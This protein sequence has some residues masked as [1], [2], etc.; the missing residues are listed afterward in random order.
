MAS[1]S[2]CPRGGYRPIY[3]DADLIASQTPPRVPDRPARVQVEE[4]RKLQ[5]AEHIGEYNIWY[6]KYTGENSFERAARA[7]TRVCLETDAGLT[8]VDHTDPGA[9]ICLHFARGCCIAGKDC[10]YRHCAPTDADE[11]RLDGE[12][13]ALNDCFGRDRHVSFR[14]DMGG[15]GT[16]NRDC[17]TL[18]IGRVCAI[19][20]EEEMKQTLIAHF[21]EFGVLESVRVLKNKGAGFIT[22]TLR[23]SA[24]FAK[25]AMAEQA[26]DHDEQVSF[27]PPIFPICHTSF[28]LYIDY[29]SQSDQRAMGARRSESSRKGDAAA[30]RRADDARCNGGAR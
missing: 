30:K 16:W 20:S 26:L 5:Q 21:G 3:G 27:S 14:D 9:F 28:S 8:R 17:R 1:A 4:K 13:E 11:T 15:T 2:L 19:P 12:R 6:G 24:E 7:S 18:Y 29:F 10:T 22:Y 23:S 25:E